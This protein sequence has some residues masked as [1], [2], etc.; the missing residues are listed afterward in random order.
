MLKKQMENLMA[1]Q[2]VLDTRNNVELEIVGVG[3]TKVI[4]INGKEY[5]KSTLKRYFKLVEQEIP[6]VVEPDNTILDDI[7]Q[8]DELTSEQDTTADTEETEVQ[9]KFNLGDKVVTNF[10]VGEVVSVP[11]LVELDGKVT[12]SNYRVAIVEDGQRYLFDY[13]EEQLEAYTEQTAQDT[14]TTAN[15]SDLQD[16]N[17]AG[18][19][20][21]EEQ[22]TAVKKDVVEGNTATT[23]STATTNTVQPTIQQDNLIQSLNNLVDLHGCYLEAKKEYIAVKKDGYKGTVCMIRNCR[24]GNGIH[25]DMK[26]KIWIALDEEYRQVVSKDHYTGIYDKT[27][28]LFRIGYVRDLDILQV[29]ILTA[30]Q[31][32][33]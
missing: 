23:N 12:M 25:I 17:T 32:A 3:E 33:S 27:R 19:E 9:V 22:D 30:L 7:E 6:E 29:V 16:N 28:K 24:Y 2:V 8:A 5:S 14:D 18:N 20:V 13:K 21:H 15:T 4:L 11:H 26:S 10:G 1:G 31:L